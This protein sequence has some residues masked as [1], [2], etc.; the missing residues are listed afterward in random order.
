MVVFW[1]VSVMEAQGSSKA[2][3]KVQI[4]YRLQL[5]KNQLIMEDKKELVKDLK[6]QLNLVKKKDKNK[7]N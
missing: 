2:L 7:L 5:F 6:Y 4:F 3:E 1:S